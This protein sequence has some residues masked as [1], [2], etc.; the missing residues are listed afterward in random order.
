[1]RATVM[2][3]VIP[4][5]VF[6]L[7]GE[8]EAQGYGAETASGISV[9]VGYGSGYPRHYYDYRRHHHRYSPFYPRAYY[10]GRHYRR[11]DYDDRPRKPRAA[12]III[13]DGITYALIDG[14]Y[15]RRQGDSYRLESP[16]RA[17]SYRVLSA[18]EKPKQRYAPG[19]TLS[20]LPE[21]KRQVRVRGQ[22]Y[23][24]HHGVW[25]ASL[26]QGGF[27]VIQPPK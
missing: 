22:L 27:V 11:H 18:Q 20:Q 12:R 5:L 19:R 3:G 15:Y 6:A 9:V 25:F 10:H 23:W 21:P 16:P 2:L 14:Q 17:G 26:E 1:M 13:V 7:A 24:V 8:A 4:T